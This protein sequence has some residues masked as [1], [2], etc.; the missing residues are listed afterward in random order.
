MIFVCDLL[1]CDFAHGVK[2][3]LS[4]QTTKVRFF[5]HLRMMFLLFLSL[6][7]HNAKM[8]PM[9]KRFTFIHTSDWHLGHS[10]YGY[11]RGEQEQAMLDWLVSLIEARQPDAV[12]VSGDIFHNAQPAVAAVERFARAVI[13]LR[14]AGPSHMKIIATAGNHDGASRHQ[15]HAELWKTLDVHVPGVVS[16][17]E[18]NEEIASANPALIHCVDER[19]WILS[20]PYVNERFLPD[21]FYQ[22]LLDA[23]A[24]RNSSR[25]PIVL[26]AHTA[27]ALPG[28][29]TE[30]GGIFGGVEAVS[31]SSLGHGY[32]YLALGHIHRPMTKYSKD[33]RTVVSYSGSPLSVSF[34]E[35][36]SHGV[37]IVTIESGD[38]RKIS[39]ERELFED[40]CPPVNIPGRG[41]ASW[42]TCVE[43]LREFP[44]DKDAFLRL[45][46][47]LEVGETLPLEARGQAESLLQGKKAR[48]CLI[49]SVRKLSSGAEAAGDRELTVSELN[50]IAPRDL[51]LRYTEEVDRK[52]DDE[53]LEL[54]DQAINELRNE[55]I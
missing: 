17:P 48:L 30:D 19:A 34:D 10:F 28:S 9:K 53:L 16:R 18:D 6:P 7:L 25:L 55:S 26:M 2:C 54:L 40:P 41:V 47:E 36:H 8:R 51:I 38:E 49:N 31:L 1:G 14:Q 21:N 52:L 23:V 43:E 42:E 24:A 4:I 12:L 13:R 46:V 15:A 22:E 29:E 3:L 39:L 32:D 27:V 44:V 11:D 37:N 45:N 20:V 50:A 5:F 33:H 35:R